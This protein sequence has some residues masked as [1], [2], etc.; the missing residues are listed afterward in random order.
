MQKLNLNKKFCNV[1][2]SYLVI[3]IIYSNASAGFKRKFLSSEK[4]TN[5]SKN[6]PLCI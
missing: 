3:V 1:H 2:F 5:I 4:A 6:P